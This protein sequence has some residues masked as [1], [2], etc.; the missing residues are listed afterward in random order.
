LNG[1]AGGFGFNCSSGFGLTC[2][3][4]GALSTSYSSWQAYG[5]AAYDTPILG[6]GMVSPFVAVFGGNSH[7]NQSF[8]QTLSQFLGG[9][10]T[11]TGTYGAITALHWNDIGA[12]AGIDSTVPVNSWLSWSFAGWVGIAARDVSLNGTDVAASTLGMAGVSALSTSATT[13]AFIANA[14]T[15][16]SVKVTPATTLRG[17]VGVNFD[18]RVPGITAP[19]WTSLTGFTELGATPAAIRYSSETSY[20]AG[21]GVTVKF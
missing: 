15:G 2:S 1:T 7:N 21:G 11:N 8:A 13:T 17:F 19:T 14:E 3:G 5:K 12:R 20:Y 10:L 6:T 18:D 9:A 16:F 4:S